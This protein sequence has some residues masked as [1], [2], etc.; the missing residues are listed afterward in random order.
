M[1]ILQ[2]LDSYR[3][4]DRYQ[5]QTLF[6][7]GPRSCQYRL[8]ELLRRQLVHAWRVVL[9]P[10]HIRRASIYLLSTRGARA[11]AEWR[12]DDPQPF[13][14][15]AD[16]AL[17]RHHHL[18]HDLA[19][20]QFFADLAA[21]TIDRPDVGLYHWVGEHGVQ[22]AYAEDRDKG[23]IPDGWGRLLIG[24]GELLL[25]LEWDRG[26]EQARRIAGK[27][28]AYVAFLI[29]QPDAECNQVLF[30]AP[31]QRR[32]EQIARVAAELVP[33]GRPCC[34]VWTTTA[35]RLAEAGPLGQS[36]RDVSQPKAP[37]A[38]PAEMP[39]RLGSARA[40]ED[41]IGKPTWWDRRPGGGEGA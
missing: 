40:V 29:D 27:V 2:A 16:H 10:G 6:F 33:K 39:A 25:H 26:S 38:A 19:A 14:T 9:R 30:V 1:A 15:R 5:I 7:E 35:A 34:R 20:N 37:L 28:R 32:E 31:N 41:C 12:D 11:L 3:Y 13:I 8:A 24:G 22:R 36:W 21:A 17:R 4:L 18:V 23:P